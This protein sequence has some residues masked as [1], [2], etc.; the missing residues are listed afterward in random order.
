MRFYTINILPIGGAPI[1]YTSIGDL[2]DNYSAL[3]IDLDIYQAQGHTPAPLGSINIYGVSFDDI[4]QK[5]NLEGAAIQVYIGMTVG[6]SIVTPRVGLIVSGQILQA[7]GNWQGTNVALSL[8]VSSN[9]VNPAE[10]INLSFNWI[11]GTPLADAVT[12]TLT[13]G[14]I[15]SLVTGSYLPSLIYTET[16]VGNYPN[17]LTFTQYINELSK[18]LNPDSL[19]AGATIVP[20]ATGFTL[21]D[22]SGLPQ[23]TIINYQD[24][25]GNITWLSYATISVK[26]I[27]RP[28]LDVGDYITFPTYAPVVNTAIFAQ[29]RNSVNFAGVFRITQLRHSGMSRQ[30]NADSWVTIID[31]AITNVA[32]I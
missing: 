21:T 31:A 20:T 30:A 23:V 13:T 7:F 25:V 22:G 12:T 5:T 9:A 15:G 18:K 28:D 19:Y 6:Y 32:M 3:Q 27:M 11:K 26:V 1:I 24:L 14:F 2:G 29:A 10:D 16:Q 8:M 4:S 17:L